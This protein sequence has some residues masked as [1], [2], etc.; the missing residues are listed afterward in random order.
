MNKKSLLIT[1]LLLMPLFAGTDAASGNELVVRAEAAFNQAVSETDS[2]KAQKLYLQS[3]NLFESA[4]SNGFLNH[5]I[6]FNIGNCYYLSNDLGRAILNY[7]K[8]E[9]LAPRNAEIKRALATAR[10]KRLDK[11]ETSQEAKVVNVLLFWHKDFSLKTRFYIALAS[12]GVL[13]CVLSAIIAGVKMPAKGFVISVVVF[14]LLCFGISARVGIMQRGIADGVIV[15]QE[16]IARTGDGEV[17]KEA[18]EKPL[19]SGTEFTVVSVRED[20]LKARF[21]GGAEAWLRK[22][23]CET[24]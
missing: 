23:D 8:A 13:C 20:W 19:H 2:V 24:F 17:Y 4:V 21:A 9:A 16:T 3:A 14:I 1:A 22:K 15:A 12:F 5:K 18:F 10:S 6:F 7:R 11:I